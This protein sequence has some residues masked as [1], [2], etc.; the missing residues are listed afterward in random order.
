MDEKTAYKWAGKILKP[1][2][3][4]IEPHKGQAVADSIVSAVLEAYS[5]GCDCKKKEA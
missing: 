1:I 5:M 4:D 2:D 3:A